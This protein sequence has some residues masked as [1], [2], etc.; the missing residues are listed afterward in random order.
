MGCWYE[1]H[2]QQDYLLIYKHRNEQ[3]AQ[4]ELESLWK[5]I[6]LDGKGKILDL[7]CGSGRHSRWL[8]NRSHQVT[9]IDLSL[10]LL[11][12]ARKA[13]EKE[14]IVYE[15][16]DMREIA[17]K[18]EFDV[19]VNLFTSFGYFDE[20]EEN[21]KV[22][23]K[24]YEALVPGGYFLF[25]FLNPSF[26]KSNLIPF[27]TFSEG[28]LII[29]QYRKVEGDCIVKRINVKDAF[30]QRTYEERVKLYSYQVLRSML[31]RNGLQ[32]IQVFGDYEG[33]S[34]CENNSPR[35]IFLCKKEPKEWTG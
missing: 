4:L 3:Q 7:C 30:S 26:L 28:D 23:K 15:R 11:E 25:D 34:L 29:N 35:T 6:P 21:E 19:V 12:E 17:Y 9:G 16:A 24:V 32:P 14:A 22:L 13:S 33:G 31:E 5:H 1:E 27:T 10:V 20:D 2:F 8:A 18:E